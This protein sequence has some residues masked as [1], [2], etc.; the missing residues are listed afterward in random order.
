MSAASRFTPVSAVIKV[1][2]LSR[3]TF[4]ISLGG[5]SVA[6]AF[7][8]DKIGTQPRKA[9][10]A[11]APYSANA[12]VTIG[13]DDS[14]TIISP[15]SEMGQGVKTSLPLLVAEDLDADWN[16]VVIIQ[17]PA[18]AKHYGNPK[19]GGVQGTG[20]SYSMQGYFQMLRLAGAQTRKM[21]LSSAAELL[22]VP[23]AEL[24]TEPSIVV[25]AAS[26]RR[27]SY[28]EIAKAG[29]LPREVVT[30]TVADLKPP[31]AWRYIGKSIPRVD[32]PAKVNGSAQFGIDV[33]L[34]AMLY[35]IVARPPVQDETVEELDDADASAVEGVVKIVRLPYG[36]GVIAISTWAAWK[37]RDALK[38]RWSSRSRVRV[39]T[40]ERVLGEFQ[41]IAN[42]ASR[43]G[44]VVAKRGDV[45]AAFRGAAKV[46]EATY[47]TD[48]VH[49]ATMEP[50]TATALVLPDGVQ[51]WGPF[52]AQNAIQDM[53]ATAV[54]TT[55]DKVSVV[56]TLLGG[57]LGRKGEMDYPLDAV[58]L[59][60]EV[61][62]R[63]VKIIWTREDD[64]RHGKYRPLSAQN[65]R[66]ALDAGGSIVG[67]RQRY[68]ADSIFARY[69]PAVYKSAGENVEG[70]DFTYAIGNLRGEYIRE[71]RGFDVGFWRGVGAGISKFAVECMLDE[72]TASTHTDPLQLRL[73]LLRHD[74]RAYRAV[75]TVADMA[76][77][78]RKREGTALGL[79]Y[80]DTYHSHV[81]QIAEVALDFET[82][83]IRVLNVWCAVD[84]G[85]AVQPDNIVAQMEGAIIHGLS[86]ALYEK[87][88]VLNGEVQESNF[89]SYR[90][91]RLS[92]I[93]QIHVQVLDSPSEA[94]GGI[95]EAGLPS[96]GPAV[97]NGIAA[98][99]GGVRLRRYPFLPDR[100][101][102]A[103]KAK[104]V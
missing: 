70:M 59:A 13:A 98:L 103:L 69:W 26:G 104:N 88:T 37:A 82:G 4:L 21:L 22:R 73:Q 40:S 14:V 68:V 42:D 75:K 72:V 19:F 63:P 57:G 71:D 27:L 43:T 84:P 23:I 38:I 16:K 77:W 7:A 95:G 80:S 44:V 91:M 39:Y 56:T 28:G 8:A 54:G 58:M 6:V 60:K 25:H 100:V 93:P 29:R 99:T 3:R 83:Q 55:A 101:L 35:G 32:I 94:P 20:G 79:A 53:A 96:I 15:S 33:E 11:R 92:E 45:E 41:A 81:A 74:P 67:W 76:G 66:V 47:C 65:V 50:M 24:S 30:V 87:I 9:G 31:A 90:V 102:A 64:V 62:G 51:V 48:H 89:N 78:T 10:V 86:H 97:A 5:L 17:A 34:P 12:W 61:P 2:R 36:I 49:H 18:D 46:L 85:V 52:Q 1:E